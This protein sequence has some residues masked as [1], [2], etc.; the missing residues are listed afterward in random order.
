M[1]TYDE[2]WTIGMNDDLKSTWLEFIKVLPM[3][4]WTEEVLKAYEAMNMTEIEL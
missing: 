4:V 3:F 2:D 1:G